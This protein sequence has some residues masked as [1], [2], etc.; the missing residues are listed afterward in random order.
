[1]LSQENI[2]LARKQLSEQVEKMPEGPQKEAARAQLAGMSDEA[3]SAMV[4]QQQGGAQQGAGKAQ[5]QRSVF[6]MIA[7][8]S[9]PSKKVD[10]NK[11]AIAVVSIR[12]VSKGHVIVIPRKIARDSNELPSSVLGL[13]KKLA[14]KMVSRLQAARTEI[15]TSSA[16]DETIVN[17]IPVYDKRVDVNSP[18]YEAGDQELEEVY[19]LL[20]VVKKPK[21]EIIR[22]RKKKEEKVVKLKRRVP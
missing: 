17:I 2:Q 20:K 12:P 14:K 21:K 16:F 22:T 5:E 1:M 3:I 19:D 7:D 18:S 15:Q 9:I 6:R 4:E 11:E 8:G 13:A 10:E